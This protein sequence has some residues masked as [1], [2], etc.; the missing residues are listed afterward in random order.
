MR[1]R[2]SKG[3]VR[4]KCGK[5]LGHWYAGGRRKSRVIGSV[6]EMTKTK[7][8]EEV[9]KIAAAE[10]G[11]R[12]EK[13]GAFVDR[14]YLPF[15]SRNWKRS[16]EGSNR[17]RIAVHLT[18]AFEDRDLLSFTRDGLQDFLDAKAAELSFSTVAHLRWDLKAIFDLA[19]AEGIVEK[20][21][22]AL[23]FIPRAA[24]KPK[25]DVMTLDQVRECFKALAQRERII[26]KF[27]ILAGMRPGEILALTWGDISDHAD[28][29]QRVYRGVIDTPKT[30]QS[31]RKAAL[32][33]GLRAELAKWKAAAGEVTDAMYVFPSENATPLQIENL[34]RRRFG[35]ALKK[36]GLGWVN[37]QVMRRTS[38]TLLNKL[39][40]GKMVADQLGHTLDVN[41][42]VYTQSPVAERR[43]IV[44]RL[45]KKLG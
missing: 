18:A 13:F 41:Q 31:A 33:D 22:A 28:I 19:Q 38:S 3:G 15:F 1:V 7:A 21:P 37:F 30:T 8:R 17:N 16:T 10:R 6:A 35:P 34:W 11:E 5:W 29:R 12:S 43:K 25:R 36:A 32:P 26:A 27:A 42:N 2:H 40:G 9:A 44:N 20:N 4:K 39:G 14:V 24:K 45:E 23:L